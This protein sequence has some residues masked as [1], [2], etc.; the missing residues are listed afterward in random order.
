MSHGDPPERLPRKVLSRARLQHLMTGEKYH[1][2]TARTCCRETSLVHAAWYNFVQECPYLF[3]RAL[4][5]QSHSQLEFRT[6]RIRENLAFQ[7][8]MTQTQVQPNNSAG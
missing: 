5:D 4:L 7:P 8:Q 6:N 3:P 1:S 2:S